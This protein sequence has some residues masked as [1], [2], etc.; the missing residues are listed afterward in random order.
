MPAIAPPDSELEDEDVAEGEADEDAELEPA[1]EA[2]DVMLED[3]TVDFETEDVVAVAA[4]KTRGLK[5]YELAEG[6][7]EAREEYADCSALLLML[8]RV[9][10]AELQQILI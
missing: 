6:L 9:S 3:P 7:A 8:V 10:W 4:I 1:D 2:V 5:V